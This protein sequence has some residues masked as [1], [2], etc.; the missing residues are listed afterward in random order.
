MPVLF[1]HASNM[2]ESPKIQESLPQGY[3]TFFKQTAEHYFFHANQSQV[4]NNVKFFLA[5][6]NLAWNFS[7][8]KYENANY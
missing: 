5:K 7:A 3:K 4:T 1:A 2:G 8:N 6:H